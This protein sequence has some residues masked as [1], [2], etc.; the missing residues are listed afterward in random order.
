[1]TFSSHS[2]CIEAA[3]FYIDLNIAGLSTWFFK[4]QNWIKRDK[5]LNPLQYLWVLFH[6]YSTHIP[7]RQ[8]Y[9]LQFYQFRNYK[10]KFVRILHLVLICS[11]HAPIHTQNTRVHVSNI[12]FPVVIPVLE[13]SSDIQ[14][15]THRY[16]D[17]LRDT[18]LLIRLPGRHMD[19]QTDT[20]TDNPKLYRNMSRYICLLACMQAD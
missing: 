19:T 3:R 10:W 20:H 6:M 13:S 16:T 9:F 17:T 15:Q 11:R 5:N 18:F 14:G 1:M 4:N 8:F 7:N 12:R 2:I